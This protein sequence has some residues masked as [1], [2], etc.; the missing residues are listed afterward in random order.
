MAR[1]TRLNRGKT[2]TFLIVARKW[3]EIS[4]SFIDA[5][6]N[7]VEHY[8][9]VFYSEK[10]KNILK[11]AYKADLTIPDPAQK[12]AYITITASET[13]KAELDVC[14]VEQ[15]YGNANYEDPQ[16]G[17]PLGIFVPMKSENIHFT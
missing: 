4:Q 13:A 8:Y 5:T 15:K 9:I 11:K 1:N 7:E 12:E 2:Y 16:I 14:L 10:N 17:T 6:W 3:D